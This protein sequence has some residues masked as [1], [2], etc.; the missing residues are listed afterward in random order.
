MTIK[1]FPFRH[2]G[3]N[4][5]SGQV[6]KIKTFRWLYVFFQQTLSNADVVAASGGRLIM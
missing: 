3:Q 5:V 4:K 6:G 1:I 2:N